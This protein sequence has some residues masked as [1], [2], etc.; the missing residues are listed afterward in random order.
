MTAPG[1]LAPTTPR[2]RTTA[3]ARGTLWGIVLAV[4]LVALGPELAGRALVVVGTVVVTLGP[5]LV[6]AAMGYAQRD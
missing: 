3:G 2:R 5:S 4:V 1:A 6:Q